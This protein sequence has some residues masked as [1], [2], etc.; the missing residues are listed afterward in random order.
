MI[1]RKP[2]R[3]LLQ[4]YEMLLGGQGG[5]AGMTEILDELLRLGL[6]SVPEAAPPLRQAAG[7]LADSALPGPYAPA[8]QYLADF[9]HSLLGGD[10]AGLVGQIHSCERRDELMEIVEAC[11]E[12]VAGVAGKKKADEFVSGILTL[13]PD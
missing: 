9:V 8:K 13:L 4:D 11:R 5:L 2:V 6:I 1:N 7:E 12:M 10:H 3:A